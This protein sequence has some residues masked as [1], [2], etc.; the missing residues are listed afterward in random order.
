MYFVG[1]YLNSGTNIILNFPS[2]FGITGKTIK[3]K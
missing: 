1:D 2:Q 3:S